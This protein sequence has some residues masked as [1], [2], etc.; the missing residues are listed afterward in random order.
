MDLVPKS[1]KNATA[2]RVGCL[3]IY[4]MIFASDTRVIGW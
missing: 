3:G 4:S 1:T 2:L